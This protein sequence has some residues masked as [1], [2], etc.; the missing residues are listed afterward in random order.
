VELVIQLAWQG[1]TEQAPFEACLAS[2][3]KLNANSYAEVYGGI[4]EVKLGLEVMRNALKKQDNSHAAE[5]TRYSVMLL[6]LERKLQKN[7]QHVDIIKSGIESASAQLNH[8]ELTHINVISKLAE[9]YREAISSLGPKIIVQGEQSVLSNPDNA[10][11]IRAL[12]LTGIRAVVLWRQAGGKRWR[13]L[14]ERNALMRE[15]DA[16]LTEV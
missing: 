7:P 5:R 16:L 9:V 10:S 2:L 6:F 3:F 13:L 8:F 15:I 4:A 12:L 11:R 1:R 14:F